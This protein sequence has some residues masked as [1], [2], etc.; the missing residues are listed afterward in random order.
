VCSA[1][2]DLNA[3]GDSPDARVPK[4]LPTAELEGFLTELIVA[5]P[6]EPAGGVTVGDDVEEAQELAVEAPAGGDDAGQEGV[7]DNSIA[8][9]VSVHLGASG[10]LQDPAWL[11]VTKRPIS[12]NVGQVIAAEFMVDCDVENQVAVTAEV[13]VLEHH[14]S[15]PHLVVALLDGGD[16]APLRDPSLPADGLNGVE[17]GLVGCFAAAS[18]MGI[19]PKTPGQRATPRESNPELHAQYTFF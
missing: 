14:I 5:M 13:D 3:L 4:I 12:T 16:V 8:G 1:P 2:S 10:A 18:R 11:R 9:P 19:E 17:D 15:P 6:P 7:V